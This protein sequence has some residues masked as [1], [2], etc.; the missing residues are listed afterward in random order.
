MILQKKIQIVTKIGLA[1]L[2]HH[3]RENKKCK[4]VKIVQ[5]QIRKIV[6]SQLK[7]QIVQKRTMILLLHVTNLKRY[8]EVLIKKELVV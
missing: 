4:R 2:G 3:T 6:S 8:F 7:P 5:H 1:A